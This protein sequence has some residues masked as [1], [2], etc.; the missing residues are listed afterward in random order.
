MAARKKDESEMTPEERFIERSKIPE[1]K[2]KR[3]RIEKPLPTP[4]KNYVSVGGHEPSLN[5]GYSKGVLTGEDAKLAI[6]AR[7]T[8]SPE[9]YEIFVANLR[10]GI[11]PEEE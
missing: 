10:K 6:K 4:S 11:R 1:Q 7:K 9:D 5:G 8:M 2:G 3:G